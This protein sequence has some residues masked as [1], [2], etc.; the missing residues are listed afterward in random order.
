MCGR[1]DAVGAPL[2]GRVGRAR[3]YEDVR[4]G[5]LDPVVANIAEPAHARAFDNEVEP[6]QLAARSVALFEIAPRQLPRTGYGVV[7]F[8][9]DFDISRKRVPSMRCGELVTTTTFLPKLAPF[10]APR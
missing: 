5:H 7:A 6:R 8:R 4:I 10:A 1:R 9:L 3:R 2:V